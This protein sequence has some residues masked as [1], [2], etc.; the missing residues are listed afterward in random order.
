MLY[1]FFGEDDFR[2]RHR[3]NEFLEQITDNKNRALSVSWFNPDTFTKE[4]FKEIV[5]GSSLFGGCYVAV[6]ENLL[7]EKG[8]ADFISE[9]LKACVGSE[10]VFVFWE[11]DLD[12]VLL[13]AL[14]KHT[15]EVEEF[16]F[17]SPREARNWLEKEAEKRGIEA[18]TAFLQDLVRQNGQNLWF[19][20]QELEK[21]ALA[22]KKD[23]LLNQRTKAAEVNIFNITDAVAAKDRSRAWFLFQ[24]ALL[25]GIDSEEIFWKI[26]WQIKNL[27]LLKK[28]L[29]LPEKKI[30]ETTRL[31]PYVVKKS[32]SAA[33][34][35]TEEELAR[36]SSELID[37]YH[38]ARRGL[39]D[40]DIGL[41]KIII[42]L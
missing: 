25:A 5:R 17:L 3:L 18:P 22:P 32:L 20:S 10:N 39:A 8:T 7:A 13:K 42:K 12:P 9:N 31:H 35:Y 14:K 11:E 2:S 36:F 23:D 24:K 28:L 21:Y 40:F 41:E 6:C 16:K 15:R 1:L 26:V 4:A 33:R 37:L 29:F 30:V 27:L 38:N 19:L 34:H